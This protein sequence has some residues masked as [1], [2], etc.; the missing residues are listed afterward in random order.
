MGESME[1]KFELY[2]T[3]D[4][5]GSIFPI[6]YTSGQT[7]NAGLLNYQKDIHKN[8]NTL[9][10]DGG[11]SLQ[12]TPLVSYYIAHSGDYAFHPMS[13]A[14]NALGLDAYTIGNHDFNYGYD[15]LRDFLKS[16]KAFCIAAN[17][18]DLGGELP[19][20]KVHVFTLENGLRIGICGV[21]TEYVN[22]WEDKE[23][24]TRLRITDPVRAAEEGSLLLSDCDV[25]ILIYHGG[26]EKS[27]ETGNVESDTRENV[28]FEIAENTDYDIILTGHQHRVVPG[29]F[30]L[31]A[32]TAQP[33]CNCR[34]YLYVQTTVDDT[35][36]SFDS[37][38][39]PV[40]DQHDPVLYQK[41]LPLQNRVEA[42]L[43][44]KIGELT[45]EIPKEEKLSAAMNGSR[46]AALINGIQL[47]WSR[48]VG[49]P[50][51]I[52]CVGLGNQKIGFP[53]DVTIR[54]VFAAYPFAN[55]LNIREIDGKTLKLALER[56][57]EYFEL[58]TDGR[59][60]ISDAFLLPKE[61]HYNYDFYAGLDYAFD[62]DC[63]KGQRVVKLKHLDGR[64]IAPDEKLRIVVSNYRSTGTGGYPMFSRLKTLYSGADNVQDLICTYFEEKSPAAIPENYR[65]ELRY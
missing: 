46:V 56:C 40:G 27:L 44:E 8:G 38:I 16:M 63:P 60:V 18:E 22:V 10:L 64:E 33:G 53:K 32:Y 55:S 58:G 45:E 20:E 4:V 2:Y 31:D 12:G 35:G 61:E 28:A 52:S 39:S 5:H 13:E 50:A 65:F 7:V 54:N 34:N 15:V 57:A 48:K 24:L 30:M 11:D 36:I 25:R 6:D 1:R 9:V 23:H 21:V 43:D 59:P 49:M 17:V 29:T 41:I 42:W 47:A 51:D 37:R 62:L 14:F 19:I 3:S 26:Y